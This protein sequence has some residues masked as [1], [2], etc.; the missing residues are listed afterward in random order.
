ML[1]KKF[2]HSL[3]ATLDQRLELSIYIKLIGT[4]INPVLK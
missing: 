1:W 4:N 3:A 2:I